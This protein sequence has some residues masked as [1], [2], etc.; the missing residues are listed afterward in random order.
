MEAAWLPLEAAGFWM[1]RPLLRTL[2]AGDQHPVLILP[3]FTTDDRSTAPLRWTLRGQ[4]YWAH[5]W[6]LG[7][8][9]GP[10]A[11]AVRGCAG[12]SGSSPT[13]TADA[14]R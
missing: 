9:I 8:N 14:S 5:A 1:I 12:A 13:N 10:T 7:P 3:G 2:G 6:R 11:Q 4:G